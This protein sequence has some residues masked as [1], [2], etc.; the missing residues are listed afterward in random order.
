MV[1]IEGDP[2]QAGALNKQEM[3]AEAERLARGIHRPCRIRNDAILKSAPQ[4]GG[5]TMLS[6]AIRFPSARIATKKR[7]RIA[8]APSVATTKA[9]KWSKSAKP[10][11]SLRRCLA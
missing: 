10:A 9:G 5:H 8:P 7:C 3:I 11:S 2:R 4:P 1:G 6:K